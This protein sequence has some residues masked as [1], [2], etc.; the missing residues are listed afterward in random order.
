MAKNSQAELRHFNGFPK[1][2]KIRQSHVDTAYA[3][4]SMAKFSMAKSSICRDQQ[5]KG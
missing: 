3:E 1:R 2:K 5:N 4:I